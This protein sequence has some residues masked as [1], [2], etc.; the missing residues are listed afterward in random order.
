MDQGNDRLVNKEKKLV[1]EFNRAEILY[2]K[3]EIHVSYDD[4]YDEY[5]EYDD[6]YDEYYQEDTVH[7]S[8]D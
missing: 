7:A 2:M 6:E 4:E 8:H 5:D 1:A 3:D